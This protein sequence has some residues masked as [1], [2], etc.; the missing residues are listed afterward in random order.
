M[1]K[2]SRQTRTRFHQIC[3]GALF[4]LSLVGAYLLRD[5]LARV[6]ALGLSPLE[7][8]VELV[9][10]LPLVAVLG[11]VFLGAQ[12][13]YAGQRPSGFAAARAAAF[14]A[15]AVVIILFLVRAQVARSV[16]LL[17]C[18]AGGAFAYARSVFAARLASTRLAREQWR[19]RVLWVGD[20][21]ANKRRR[22]SL[23]AQEM[24]HIADVGDFDPRSEPPAHLAELLHKHAVN[25]AIF[26]SAGTAQLAPY[27]DCCTREG[28]AVIICTGLAPLSASLDSA[29]HLD[30]LGGEMVVHF[31][32]HKAG[33]SAL[34][35]KRA[36]DVLFSAAALVLLSPVFA[37]A[38]LTI[39]L[40]SRGPVL[41]RQTRAGLNG[42]P[43]E[44][45][46]FRTMRAGAENEQDALADKNEMRGPV[47]K[48][49]DDPRV[50]P[51]GR[52][53]RRHAI[54]ELP[55]LW[56]VLRGEMSLVGPRPLPLYEVRRFDDD[57]HRRRQSMRP[58]LTCLWQTSGRNDIDDFAEWVRLDLA[59]IDHWSPWLDARI[60]LA[61]IPVVIS[62]RGGR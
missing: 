33:P 47:F 29:A 25:T 27:V 44:M 17:G 61:T 30:S 4:A 16:I 1:L 13:F 55:Q 31:R 45:V 42:R 12:R 6:D 36:T 37:L 23:S 11:P 60:V 32:A 28:V 2:Q 40:T 58:G 5:G 9:W 18:A 34:A 56:N 62:G 41:F 26:D 38:A 39:K 49:G 35:L 10:V 54:D 50:T 22:A 8:F 53:F 3:D 21:D 24:S 19:E 51:A 20:P 52:F 59:Y 57:A 15:L 48:M 7:P 14:T 43:F 46:K